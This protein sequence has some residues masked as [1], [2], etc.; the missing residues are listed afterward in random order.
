MTRLRNDGERAASAKGCGR[1]ALVVLLL[2][3]AL[4]VIALHPEAFDRLA[5]L[6]LLLGP[7][8]ATHA[9]GTMIQQRVQVDVV[10]DG[11]IEDYDT[12]TQ[13]R[14]A[15]A[16]AAQAGVSV[17]DVHLVVST[18]RRRQLFIQHLANATASMHDHVKSIGQQKPSVKISIMVDMNTD[19]EGADAVAQRLKQ[20]LASARSASHALGV[21][22]VAKPTI[23]NHLV[24][25][26]TDDEQLVRCR[27]PPPPPPSPPP[28]PPPP[29][30]SPPPP[31]PSPP[32]PPP[33]SPS[34][35]PPP[36]PASSAAKAAVDARHSGAHPRLLGDAAGGTAAAAHTAAAT[37]HTAA[38]A[39]ATSAT[40]SAAALAA[41]TTATFSA[42]AIA[43]PTAAAQSAVAVAT[44]SVA[45]V[46]LAAAAALAVPSFAILAV[47]TSA[48]AVA[49]STAAA[50]T[51][52][53]PGIHLGNSFVHLFDAAPPPPPSPQSLPRRPSRHRRPSRR[54]PNPPHAPT[55]HLDEALHIEDVHLPFHLL[56]AM[57]P[58]APPSP[59]SPPPPRA[60]LQLQPFIST[61]PCTSTKR[62]CPFTSWKR[63]RT[64]RPH[65]PTRH[66]LRARR[67]RPPF[68]S[69]RR[70]IS[71]MC[72]CPSICLSPR[73][74]RRH[75]HRRRRRRRLRHRR[76]RH[77]RRR[78]HRR[79]HHP[80]RK[81]SCRSSR[82]CSR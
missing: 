28:P 19:A 33:P 72:T 16:L 6:R 45:A 73:C 12:E 56:E 14:I 57:P 9:L 5:S 77:R 37:L 48:V 39:T 60:H 7:D 66:R 68:T 64:H 58:T 44:V 81:T 8:S 3:V 10:T 78:R 46:A 43:T 1:W 26:V 25:C 67:S 30:P 11:R 62:T 53:D 23:G 18:G 52:D 34:P 79:R 27:P 65:H 21:A 55:F 24:T 59:P 75:R 51:P 36:P 61:R 22:A 29:S 4:P 32:P 47:A 54:P 17:D 40:F 20:S 63:C 50:V 71:R 82:G 42:A 35:P 49:T 76:P 69:R 41:A 13:A 2:L 74:R 15:A 31:P 70:C 80:P 38:F